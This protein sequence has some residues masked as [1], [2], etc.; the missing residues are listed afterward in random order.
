MDSSTAPGLGSLT[1]VPAAERPELLAAPV[2][3][4]LGALT[5]PAWV[6]EI[7]PDLADT[8]AFAEA[9]GVPLEVSANCVVV[10]AR[11]AGQTELAVCLV[12]AT[13]RADVNGLVRRHLGARKVSFAP[14]DVAVAESG[15]EYGGITPLGL[16]PSWPVLVDPAVAA[17]DLVVVGSG[18]RGSKL[19]VSGAALAALPA[20]EVLEG[21]GRPVA[22]PPRPAPAAP[23]ERAPDDRDV[24][25]GERPEELSAADR[26]YLEDRPPHWG[27]D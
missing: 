15:M 8:A 18:T 4:A 5:A 2:A 9:Y 21:L 13:T 1:W 27:S 24:G 11:R 6:A 23:A 26:R 19:A 12:P 22:E 16:P 17:A 14:Q 3:A 25:W 7:D 10:A 20:A